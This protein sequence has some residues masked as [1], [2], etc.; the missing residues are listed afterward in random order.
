MQHLI[1]AFFEI[2]ERFCFVQCVSF[3]LPSKCVDEL[4]KKITKILSM[5]FYFYVF[6]G[7]TLQ[8]AIGRLRI[9]TQQQQHSTVNIKRNKEES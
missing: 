3:I 4:L 8:Y 9:A 2:L 5:Y 7:W 1:C 6:G